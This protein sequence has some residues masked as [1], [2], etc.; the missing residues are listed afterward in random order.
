MG[1]ECEGKT[2]RGSLMA[3]NSGVTAAVSMALMAS[4]IT[5]TTT[6]TSGSRLPVGERERGWAG[7]VCLRVRLGG[8][9]PGLGWPSWAGLPFFF[10]FLFLFFFLF[11]VF[12]F[13]IWICNLFDSN[14]HRKIL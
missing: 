10:L 4:V 7:S 6:L 14:F 13:S 12:N 8:L 1:E 5:G 9:D 11:S 3:R 2:V